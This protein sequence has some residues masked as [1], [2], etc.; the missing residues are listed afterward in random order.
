MSNEKVWFVT[1]V[2]AGFGLNLVKSLLLNGQR[3]AALAGNADISKR[4][5]DSSSPTRRLLS[6]TADPDSE[7]SIKNAV[8]QTI[9]RF[10]RIDI[11]VNNAGMFG[12]YYVLKQAIPYLQDQHAG[13]IINFLAPSA[14]VGD[15]QIC[16][17]TR[18]ALESLS[19]ALLSGIEGIGIK[20]TSVAEPAL[21]GGAALGMAL[22]GEPMS[23]CHQSVRRSPQ[24][25][26]Q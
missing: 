15:C 9:A 22:L 14:P 13:H 10:G 5:M 19:E 23:R 7:E 11:V 21:F 6:F 2:S 16:T 18:L 20:V 4:I 25:Q 3:V 1:E 17:A 8:E 26:L 24:L 12:A